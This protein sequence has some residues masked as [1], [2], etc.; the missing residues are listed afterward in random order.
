MESQGTWK[1]E[2]HRRIINFMLRDGSPVDP[3]PSYYGWIAHDYEKLFR[4]LAEC[5]SAYSSCTWD[6]DEWTEFAGTFADD[7]NCTGL[8]AIITCACGTVAGRMWRYRGSYAELIR[9][10]TD[11]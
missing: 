4:H 5:Q 9:G 1:Q 3:K 10:L 7:R 11:E 6:D 8:K 2:I